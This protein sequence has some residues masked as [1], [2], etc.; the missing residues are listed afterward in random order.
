MIQSL[1]FFHSYE[2]TTKQL[3]LR[4]ATRVPEEIFQFADDIEILD[5]AHGSLTDLPENFADLHKL[6]IAF[7]SHNPF[8]EIP[9][10]LA[11]CTNLTMAGFKS[12]SLTSWPENV[13]PTS[14]RWLV[15]TDNQLT[16]VPTSI[17]KLIH[18]Q[19]LSLAGNQISVLPDEMAECQALELIRLGANQLTHVPQ[20]IQTLPNLGWYGDAGNRYSVQSEISS[21]SVLKISWSD[22]ALGDVIGESPSSTVYKASY[23]SQPVAVKIYKG[24]L[25][26]DGYIADDI[27]AA[28]LASGHAHVTKVLGVL[29]KEPNGAQGVI[30]E[31]I[32]AEYTGLGLPPSLDSCTRDT[33]VDGKVFSIDVISQIVKDIASACAHLHSKGIMHGDIYAH[34]ILVNASGQ[35]ILGDFGAATL[36]DPH[37]E[38][39]REHVEVRAFGYLVEELLER[40]SNKEENIEIFE[41]IQ[42]I[43][44]ADTFL[45]N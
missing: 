28:I 33:Y 7:F 1:P 34:N 26:S 45:L 8:T 32:P 38:P 36:Y 37:I 17:G 16:T 35:A 30:L 3:T 2:P 20:W 42:Q 41:R 43:Q 29:T 11:Q 9:N 15:L 22:I 23:N 12:C 5:L 6:R 13:L 4:G 40:C 14:L 25:T 10:V 31:L 18:L 27:H 19:K 21:S 24:N 39:W 44:N